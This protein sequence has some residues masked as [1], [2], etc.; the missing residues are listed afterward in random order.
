[1][2]QGSDLNH[3]QL[4]GRVGAPPTLSHFNHGVEFYRFPLHVRRLS[5]TEDRINVVLPHSLLE[6]AGELEEGQ[7][8]SVWGEVRTFNNRSG[9]GSR[10]VISTFARQLELGPGLDGNR[11]ELTGTLCKPPSLRATPLGRTIC[12]MIL[13]VN[14]RYGR[15]DY[16]PCIAWGS[17]A[18]RCGGLQV[19]DRV[20][21]NGRLQSREYTKLVGEEL[22]ERLAFEVS[23]MSLVSETVGE[24]E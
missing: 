4:H 9:I 3:I 2:R 14:R 22:E 6:Q 1:M 20:H 5:G 10:L 24:G 13:A 17:L 16:L 19:G 23:V 21:L 11:L 15:A 12:D 18:H 7:E 8:A